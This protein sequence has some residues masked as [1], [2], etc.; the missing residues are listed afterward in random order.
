MTMCLE[1]TLSLSFE[2]HNFNWKHFKISY[3]EDNYCGRLI[4]ETLRMKFTE[5]NLNYV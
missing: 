5:S 4:S 3:I 2:S 1:T